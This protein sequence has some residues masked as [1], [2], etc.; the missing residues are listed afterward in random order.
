MVIDF[1][2]LGKPVYIEQPQELIAWVGWVIL[3][4]SVIFLLIRWKAE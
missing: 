2:L 4:S 3:L 1:T